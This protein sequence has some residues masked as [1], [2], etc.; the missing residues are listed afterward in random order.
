MAERRAD[1][2]FRSLGATDARQARRPPLVAEGSTASKIDMAEITFFEVL[3][4]AHR[5]IRLVE[6]SGAM[7]AGKAAHM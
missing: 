7:L 5:F 1:K 6:L 4:A 3:S 2:V